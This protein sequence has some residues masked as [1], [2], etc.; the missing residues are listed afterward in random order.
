MVVYLGRCSPTPAQSWSFLMW[1]GERLIWG[2]TSLLTL[3]AIFWMAGLEC[4]TRI[5]H[6]DTH[7]HT[8]ESS[9]FL[10]ALD[11][12]LPGSVWSVCVC[13]FQAGTKVFCSPN[14]FLQ[15]SEINVGFISNFFSARSNLPGYILI[16]PEGLVKSFLIIKLSI[17]FPFKNIRIALLDQTN[18]QFRPVLSS[19]VSSQIMKVPSSVI[20]V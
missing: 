14:Y 1:T 13:L 11:S 16:I 7:C 3:P 9:W 8:C 19:R 15:H 6:L 12:L 4:S 5:G 2:L 17:T 18:S 20:C 10:A